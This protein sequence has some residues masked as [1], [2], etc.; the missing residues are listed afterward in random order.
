[1]ESPEDLRFSYD[2]ENAMVT[3][4]RQIGVSI[5]IMQSQA[6]I[7]EEATAETS[8]PRP[9]GPPL[10]VRH[11]GEDDSIFLNQDYLIKGVAGSIFWKLMRDYKEKNR[12]A[13]TNRELR[14][15]PSI[16]LPDLSDNLEARLVLLHR[17]LLERDA[18][19]TWRRPGAGVFV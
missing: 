13:F 12:T 2:Y 6:E 3:L 9:G 7:T 17:R 18:Q 10:V 1:M 8:P 14:L 16:Q 19:C 15:D 11:Y 4:A 5:L